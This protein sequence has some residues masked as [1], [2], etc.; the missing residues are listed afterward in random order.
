MVKDIYITFGDEKKPLRSL[1]THFEYY[2]KR[3]EGISG[4]EKA[5]RKREKIIKG[6]QKFIENMDKEELTIDELYDAIVTKARM[7]REIQY[8]YDFLNFNG[9]RPSE[10]EEIEEREEI[11]EVVEKVVEERKIEPPVIGRVALTVK[12]PAK[13]S[14]FTFWV[15]E[16][17]EIKDKIH[18]FPIEPGRL[19]SVTSEEKDINVLGII[20]DV[21][22]HADI[23]SPTESFYGHGVGNPEIEMPTNPVVITSAKV[24]V[25][26]R[27]DRKAEPLMGQ[28]KVRPATDDEI[29]K[30][31]GSEISKDEDELLI[32]FGYDW[33]GKPVPIPAHIR[34][35]IG[36]EAAHI[37]ISGAAGAATKTSYALFLLFS[38]L[39]HSKQKRSHKVAAIAFNVKEADLLRIDQLPT[40][41]EIDKWSR[42]GPNKDHA[43]L[44]K[45]IRDLQEP[46]SIDPL[47]LK[48]N[49]KFFVPERGDGTKVTLRD[50]NFPSDGFRYGALDLAETRSLHLLLDPQDL[51]DKSTA[52]LWSLMD[53]IREKKFSF[54]EALDRLSEASKSGTG[55]W[56][57]G[58]IG[59]VPHHRDTINKVRNRAEN[60]VRYQLTDL[61][62]FSDRE[63]QPIPIWDLQP[64][65]LWI[66]DISRL[67]D[68]GQRLLFHWIMRALHDFL[69]KKRSRQTTTKFLNKKVDLDKLQIEL[70]IS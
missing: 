13:P 55:K 29:R 54:K 15:T 10:I 21:E 63:G 39:A 60:A 64:G 45:F 53:E 37:N 8:F 16:D 41:E 28:W 18:A 36:Y 34:H 50:P 58:V 3:E 22:T 17:K 7:E 48:K 32:G 69:E 14:E 2:L 25:V 59:G 40:W 62:V 4:F 46:Y 11:A 66:I 42:S 70:W 35:I 56:E 30:A 20:S 6:V 12:S 44:W 47:D 23:E 5:K 26:Y 19:V 38:I 9:Y 49:F 24:E 1:L 67:H 43:S 61:L 52:V 27:S 31:Y 33:R 57:G 65:D 51:D 68:K